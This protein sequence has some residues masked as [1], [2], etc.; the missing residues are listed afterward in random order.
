VKDCSSLFQNF[1]VN[2]HKYH[3]VL[4]EIITVRL[5]YHKFCTRWVLIMPKMQI[6]ASAL[7][8]LEKYHKGGDEFLN[9]II[10]VMWWNLGFICECWYQRTVKAVDAHTF[11]K[12]ADKV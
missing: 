10:W 4:Y 2:F 5:G 1:H 11:T 6:M 9:H 3:A 7:T 12:Q 8:F